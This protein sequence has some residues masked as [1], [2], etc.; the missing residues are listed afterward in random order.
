VAAPFPLPDLCDIFRPISTPVLVASTVPCRIWP[1]FRRGMGYRDN[2]GN[3][4]VRWTHC[5]DF[6]D[7]VDVRDHAQ[8]QLNPVGGFASLVVTP[9][10][11]IIAILN[12]LTF[13]FWVLYVEQRYTHT[14]K[15][16][17]RAYVVRA[18]TPYPP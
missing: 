17:Q 1:D 14:T 3:N 5:I 7:T 15:S 16:Y 8:S 11:Q 13:E 10:D 6:Q 4:L 18:I 12:L 2:V 9:A